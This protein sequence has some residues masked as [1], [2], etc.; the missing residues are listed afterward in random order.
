MFS[1][2][3]HLS[4]DTQVVSISTVNNPAANMGVLTSLNNNDLI[5][6]EYI[7]RNG[8]AEQHCTPS[9]NFLRKLHAVFHSGRTSLPSHPQCI[10]VPFSSHTH[11]RFFF[12]FRLI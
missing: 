9:F 5:S 11:Q 4:T 12:F 7:P 2:F 3:V 8:I 6:F 1:L 10:R